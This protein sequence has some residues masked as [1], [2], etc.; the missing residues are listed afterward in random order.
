MSVI[1]KYLLDILKTVT[2][3]M[4]E[5]TKTLH[6]GMQEGNLVLWAHT[7][8]ERLGHEGAKEVRTFR[9]YG[10]GQPI[11]DQVPT[12]YIGTVQDGPFVWHIFEIL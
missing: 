3:V 8:L 5:G 12:E 10:T 6:V 2:H 7:N 1:Y 11:Q 4:P 9:C